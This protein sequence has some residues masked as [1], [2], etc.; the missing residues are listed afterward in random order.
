MVFINTLTPVLD[1]ATTYATFTAALTPQTECCC[2]N[3]Q[4][5]RL[6]YQI[7]WDIWKAVG[8]QILV[9]TISCNLGYFG[10]VW[11]ISY[12]LGYFDMT[13]NKIA[14]WLIIFANSL[15]TESLY[16]TQRNLVWKIHKIL[17]VG[18]LKTKLKNAQAV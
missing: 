8:Q 12:Y 4:C 5:L 2:H 9:W 17:P 7:V 11:H 13:R 3:Q 18:F 10:K 1:R 16:F 6:L 14:I 15:N